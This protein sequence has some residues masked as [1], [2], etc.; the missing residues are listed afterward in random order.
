VSAFFGCLYAGVAAVP[1]NPPRPNQSVVRLEAIAADAEIG[2]VLTST[3]FQSRFP[4]CAAEL[5]GLAGLPWLAVDAV[6]GGVS[7][8]EVPGRALALLQYTSGSTGNPK[9]VQLTHAN[10]VHNERMIARAFGHDANSRVVGWL[11]LYHDMG[12]IGNV[13]QPVFMGIPCVL[14]PPMAF[15]QRPVRWLRAITK[16]RGTT[17]GAPNFAY[18]LC[19]QRISEEQRDGLDLASWDLAYSG[20]EPVRAETMDRFAASF[21]ECGFR[22]QTYFPCYGLAEATLYVTGGTKMRAAPRVERA[23]VTLVGCGQAGGD[24]TV[25]VVDPETRRRCADGEVG[26]IWVS[27]PSVSSGYWSNEVETREAFGARLVDGESGEFLRTGDLGF[28]E[29]GDLFVTGRIKDVIIIRGQNHYPQDIERTAAGAHSAL[30]SGGGAAFA[31]DADGTERL[32]IVHEVERTQLRSLDVP[33]VQAAVRE[34]VTA[35]HGIQVH[36]LALVKPGAVPRTTS[37]KIRRRH[38]RELLANGSLAELQGAVK[39]NVGL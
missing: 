14:M 18:D 8:S 17:S 36:R 35:Q 20:A 28:F 10:L 3:S 37:G 31:V 26:E 7:V 21:A 13:L 12:L 24:G 5:P 25:C 2:V 4:F 38:C 23:G 16:Y 19:C 9:G 29:R 1:T 11:P 39:G 32:V 6:P 15:L 27:G 33:A 30:A 34:N 22:Q